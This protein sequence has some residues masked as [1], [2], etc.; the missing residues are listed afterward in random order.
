MCFLLGNPHSCWVD[1]VITPT[2]HLCGSVSM[3]RDKLYAHIH[4]THHTLVLS[5]EIEDTVTLINI[6]H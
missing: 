6:Q 1:D 3:L 2:A 4:P 5:K